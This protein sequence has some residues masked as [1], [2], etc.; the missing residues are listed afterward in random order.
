MTAL[1]YLSGLGL[2]LAFIAGALVGMWVQRRT[3]AQVHTQEINRELAKAVSAED[4]YEE[5]EPDEAMVGAG[6]P[7]GVPPPTHDQARRTSRKVGVTDLVK[8]LMAKQS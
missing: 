1:I 7:S 3:V 8:R 4:R 6:H 5:I 2:G